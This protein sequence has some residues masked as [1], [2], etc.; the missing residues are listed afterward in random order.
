M[1][2]FTYVDANHHSF[3]FDLQNLLVLCTLHSEMP[4][5]YFGFVPFFGRD[6]HIAIVLSGVSFF[7]VHF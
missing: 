4:P 6:Q 5:Q 7:K 3:I 2:F 1:R